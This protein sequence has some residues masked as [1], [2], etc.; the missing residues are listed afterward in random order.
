MEQIPNFGDVRTLAFCAFCGGETGTRDHC[1][2]KVFLDAPLPENL[3]VVP[4]C[5]TCNSGFSIDEEYFACLVACIVA[6]TTDPAALPRAKISKILS[7]KQ[8]LRAMLEAARTE[9]DSRIVFLFDEARVKS[10]LIKLAQGH[11]LYELHELCTRPPDAIHISPL[12]LL[13]HE[14]REDFESPRGTA[15]W[16][17]V[18]SRSMH[19]LIEGSND[20]SL[21]GWLV[22]QPE[23]YRYNACLGNG[24]EVRIV[25]HE[26]L[27]CLA[28]WDF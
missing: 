3:P 4:A 26:Y 6:G 15:L 28:Q 11:A 19:R 1:P 17:E 5:L 27:A 9:V 22:V 2:S 8:A 14:Q 13:S 20:L 12:E 16:P 25:I 23:R 7:E 21:S 18:G 10:V 24:I